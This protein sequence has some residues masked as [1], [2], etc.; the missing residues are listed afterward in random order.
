MDLSSHGRRLGDRVNLHQSHSPP[1]IGNLQVLV[2]IDIFWGDRV[3]L[4]E[5]NDYPNRPY[6]ICIKGTP[7]VRRYKDLTELHFPAI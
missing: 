1:P 2:V 3:N 4:S 7:V 6:L 5:K